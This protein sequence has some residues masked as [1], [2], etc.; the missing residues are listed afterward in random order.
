MSDT[1]T[2]ATTPVTVTIYTT[3]TCSRCRVLARRLDKM[4]LTPEKVVLDQIDPDVKTTIMDTFDLEAVPLTI[5]GGLFDVPVYFADI[6][7]SITMGIAK[8]IADNN[9]T[10]ELVEAPL[11]DITYLPQNIEFKELTKLIIGEDGE[12]QL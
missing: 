5:I 10:V 1:T 2:T 4:G 11:D 6:S 3:S 9:I 12:L 7:P 8:Y